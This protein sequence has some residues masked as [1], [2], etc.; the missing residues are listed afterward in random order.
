M[1]NHPLAL[2]IYLITLSYHMSKVK[3]KIHYMQNL[4]TFCLRIK[5]GLRL[6][7]VPP[8]QVARTQTNTF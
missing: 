2:L 8:S 6:D 1:K 5:K 4:F 7:I 3:Q